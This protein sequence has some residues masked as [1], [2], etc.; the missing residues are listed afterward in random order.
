MT[1][2]LQTAPAVPSGAAGAAVRAPAPVAVAGAV[3]VAVER[4]VLGVDTGFTGTGAADHLLAD[5]AAWLPVGVVACTHLVRGGDLAPGEDPHVSV[6][7]DLPGALDPAVADELG[8]AFGSRPLVVQLLADD[9]VRISDDAPA[10]GA[11]VAVSEALTRLAGR[12]VLFPGSS[13]LVGS[14]TV[15]E[16]LARS[17][18]DRVV[19]L[20]G[21]EVDATTV[22]H[23]RDFVRPQRVGRL[24]EL[25]VQPARGGTVVPFEDPDP[26]PCCA[27][28]AGER[29]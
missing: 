26:T 22:V 2:A 19:D 8:Q 13:A 16:V 3:A 27:V 7:L 14:L 4:T 29:R 5:L 11:R 18:L 9:D 17:A 28:H 12:A 6:S 1:P 20:T 25:T 23:T 24:L 10:G 21:A 15:G